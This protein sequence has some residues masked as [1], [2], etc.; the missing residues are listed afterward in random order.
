MDDRDPRRL[1]DPGETPPTLPGTPRPFAPAD[2]PTLPGGDAPASAPPLPVQSRLGRYSLLEQLGHGGMGVVWK[3]WDNELRRVVCLKLIRAEE[4][5]G[6]E[7]LE[8]FL[9]EARLAARLRHP[10]ILSVHDVG[11]CD[12]RHYLTMDL[13][14]GKTL[15]QVLDRSR[16]AKQAGRSSA[17][18]DLRD[19]LRILADVAD[20]VGYAHQN[21]VV[22]RDVKPGNVLVD[23][24]GHAW[25]I[26]FGLAKETQL[27]QDTQERLRQLTITGAAIGTPAYMSPEQ[28]EG[29]TAEIGPASDVWALGVM[30]YEALTG[31]LPFQGASTGSL[32]ITILLEEPTPPRKRCRHVPIELEAVCLKA[33]EKEKARRYRTA[34]EF[35]EEL[36]RWLRGEPVL[37]RSHGP[38]YRAWRW[39][40]RRKKAVLP[41]AAALAVIAALG[42]WGWRA[43]ARSQEDAEARIAAEDR[44]KLDAD[45]RAAAEDRARQDAEARKRLV[46]G[47]YERIARDAAGFEDAVK[48]VRMPLEAR[49][50]MAQPLLNMLEQVI[51]EE[52]GFGPAWS[53]RGRVRMMLGEGDSCER[54]LDEGCSR[55]PEFAI[56]WYLRGM[57]YVEKY[58]SSRALPGFDVGSRGVVFE[59]VLPEGSVERAWKE[60]GLADLDRMAQVAKSDPLIAEPQARIGRAMALLATSGEGAWKEALEALEGVKGAHASRLRGIALHHLGR[61]EEAARAFGQALKDWPEDGET[62]LGKGDAET[63]WAQTL[64][65][66]GEDGRAAIRAAIA[67]FGE[68]V[69]RKYEMGDA[70]YNRGLGWLTL[71]EM[72]EMRGED[73][74]ESLKRCIEDN[75]ESLRH[76]PENAETF[77]NRGIAHFDLGEWALRNGEAA[78]EHYEKALADYDE[79]V[80]RSSGVPDGYNN[81]GNAYMGLGQAL[82]ADGE[83]PRDCYRRAIEQYELTLRLDTK[84]ASTHSNLG[85]ALFTLAEEEAARGED[86]SATIERAISHYDDAIRLDPD[87]VTAYFNRGSALLDLAKAQAK[88][89]EDLRENCRKAI[90]DFSETISR[91]PAYAEAYNFCALARYY[92]GC[93]EEAV[94]E[95]AAGSFAKAEEDAK[96]AIQG[97]S[98]TARY[99]LGLA[100]EK[101]GRFDEAVAAFEQVAREVPPMAAQAQKAVE[102]V[103]AAKRAAGDPPK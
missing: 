51:A 11:E 47:L 73:P 32:I 50:T 93:V 20:A 48:R 94:G 85:S 10:H 77:L 27:G 57:H 98:R 70:C 62:W 63:A 82:S 31:G 84:R 2:T 74:R 25:V 90:E 101:T 75:S 78:R 58:A 96:R 60:R 97:G 4:A 6:P 7:A 81:R 3:A 19:E 79:A 56:V 46:T 28:A 16:E 92:I 55:A 17:H 67:S 69:E 40:S 45:A 68:A 80:R 49:V 88:R 44:A 23:R 18:A 43:R 12:G 15:A 91:Q 100:L 34:D 66:E 65:A 13:V 29:Q 33:M 36:R 24:Q 37:A 59:E 26:D 1:P 14:E 41:A 52:P 39:A 42:V 89:Q 64:D 54:D 76:D 99:N 83:D 103:R 21:G 22:H 72:D 102:R 38:L 86:A 30:L 8:R 5:G 61:F 35:A 87:L 71:A 53:W 95:D 9:R